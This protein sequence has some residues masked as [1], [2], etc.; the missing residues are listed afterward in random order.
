MPSAP[1]SLCYVLRSFP[2]PSETFIADEANS[3][4]AQGV[5]VSVVHLHAGN[6]S[7]VHPSS[8]QLLEQGCVFHTRRPGRWRSAASLGKLLL[9][10]PWQT[11]F[12]LGKALRSPHRWLYF[13]TL[14]AAAWCRSRGVDFFHAHFADVNLQAAQALSHWLG[15]PFGVTTH[16]YDILDD[17]IEPGLAGTLFR[18]SSLVVT[19]SRWNVNQMAGK[20]ALPAE[21]LRIVHCGVDL[22]AFAFKERSFTDEGPFRLLNVGRLMPVKAQAVLLHA[23]AQVRAQGI[24]CQ[25]D[26]I[27]GGPLEGDLR[28]LA[29][30]LGLTDCVTLHGAQAQPFVRAC[31]QQAHAFVL[32]STSEGL[33]VACIEAAAI[34][35]PL[36]ATRITGLPE[37]IDDGISGLLVEPSDAHAL[38][39]AIAWAATHRSALPAM[40]AH[41]RTK[42]ESEF[43]RTACTRQ[44]LALMDSSAKGAA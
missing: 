11:L 4:A 16:R 35:T 10:Q 37:L 22:G 39:Q 40:A 33:P 36:I 43:D 25:L 30:A 29:L 13:S 26:I 31:L 42:V 41:A 18:D 21:G 2:E 28:Q 12:G 8:Q 1:R 17:P 23:V 5:R 3:V 20:Y 14:P 6:S 34:G 44:L 27:G 9:Q 7:V 19:I 32:S 38:A 15:R 24:A